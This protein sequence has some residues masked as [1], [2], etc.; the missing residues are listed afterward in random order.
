MIL[1]PRLTPALSDP[2]ASHGDA[3][4][5]LLLYGLPEDLVSLLGT[6]DMFHDEVPHHRVAGPVKL[7][8]EGKT[9]SFIEAPFH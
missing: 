4:W 2:E 8:Q 1:R 3:A 7:S 9:E 5:I 6:R